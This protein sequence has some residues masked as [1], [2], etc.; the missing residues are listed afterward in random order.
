VGVSVKLVV[1]EQRQGGTR[2]RTW[3][4]D[5]T[6]LDDDVM[7]VKVLVNLLETHEGLQKGDGGVHVEI[8]LLADEARVRDGRDLEDEITRQ[9]L[10]M[11]MR[12]TLEGL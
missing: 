4:G 2:Q 12:L 5:A 8:V 3:L 11:L 6:A 9:V 10:R 1:V 7:S